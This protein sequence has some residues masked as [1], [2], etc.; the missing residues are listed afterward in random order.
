MKKFFSFIL[1]SALAVSSALQAAQS[2]KKPY[3]KQD[4]K[5]ASRPVQKP[6]PAKH[7]IKKSDKELLQEQVKMLANDKLTS[8]ALSN[9][10]ELKDF[11]YKN[12]CPV[13][14]W[15]K[16]DQINTAIWIRKAYRIIQKGPDK[17]YVKNMPSMTDFL[18][19]TLYMFS[20]HRHI[21][22]I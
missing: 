13:K 22:L 21:I 19:R 5:P 8:R 1:C 2:P 3:K 10:A 4:T 15:T 6:R 11:C 18:H 9:Y 20:W 7:I 16:Q 12:L 17:K 14:N